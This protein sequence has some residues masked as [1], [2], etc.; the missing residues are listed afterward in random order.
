MMV[1]TQVARKYLWQGLVEAIAMSH[2]SSIVAIAYRSPQGAVSIDQS[3][4][5][6]SR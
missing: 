1:L 4:T 2:D 6:K 3:F 5:A